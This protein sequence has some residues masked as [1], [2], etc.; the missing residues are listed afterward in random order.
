LVSLHGRIVI[1]RISQVMYHIAR[2][3]YW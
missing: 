3:E 1:S 2:I